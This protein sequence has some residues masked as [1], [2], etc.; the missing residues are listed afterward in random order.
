MGGETIVV[1]G[2]RDGKMGVY[3][4]DP[5]STQW[6]R[7]E[8]ADDG[9]VTRESAG[10]PP[11]GADDLGD[12]SDTVKIAITNSANLDEA[13]KAAA[14]VLAGIEKMKAQLG[15]LD[16]NTPLNLNGKATT[17]G[18]ELAH[19]KNINFVVTDG[20]FSKNGGVGGAQYNE[21]GGPH[22]VSLHFESFD[23]DGT[24]DYAHPN[25]TH[26]Q[27]LIG[28][29]AHEMGHLSAEDDAFRDRSERYHWL[30]NIRDITKLEFKDGAYFTGVEAWAN[31]YSSDLA[32]GV[33]LRIDGWRPD[34]GFVFEDP[35][36]IYING[37]GGT[38]RLAWSTRP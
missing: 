1:T 37:G 21:N 17:A 5:S 8:I 27:G 16:L 32:A 4:Y 18:A 28:I 26:M 10:G 35:A 9:T 23:R 2:S 24:K 20:D 11:S 14:N 33:G 12:Y 19:L 34:E 30:E 15:G 25:Y 7:V 36:V 31:K 3:S 22:T 13:L 38:P 29:I 6:Y